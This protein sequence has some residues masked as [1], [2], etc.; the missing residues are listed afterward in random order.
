LVPTSWFLMLLPPVT[1]TL[2]SGRVVALC[3]CRPTGIGAVAV[4]L[5]TGPAKSITEAAL[6]PG[7]VAL[8]RSTL[9]GR[10]IASD[11]VFPPSNV[12]GR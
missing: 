6:V 3:H 5:G 4:I 1:T 2:P 12:D 10:N 7:A 8:L 11:C 9:K